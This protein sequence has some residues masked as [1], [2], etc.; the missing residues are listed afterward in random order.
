MTCMLRIAHSK[1]AADYGVDYAFM[2]LMTLSPDFS[3]ANYTIHNDD[4]SDVDI[5]I[6]RF[7]FSFD[8]FNNEKSNLQLELT[9]AYQYTTQ[10]VPTF[11]ELGEHIDAEWDTYGADLGFICETH[12]TNNLFFTPS[13]RFGISRMEN[14]ADYN[15][16]LTNIIIKDQ[17]E[18]TIFNWKT[19]VSVLNLGV[20]LRY[21]WQLLDRNSSIAANIYHA[22]IDSFSES[23]DTIQFS[24]RANMLALKAD[25]I[26]P[27]DLTLIDY[28][29]D[30]VL[31]L[32]S[33][34][35]FGENRNTL[36][37]TTSYQG[38][39]GV[40]FPI[41]FKQK[42]YGYLRLSGQ[43]LRAENM[44]GWLLTLGHNSK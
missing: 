24:E 25:M 33:N 14:H 35:F 17:F 40:E 27:T 34:H 22:C 37:Y 26:F 44:E 31:L 43:L 3:A 29:I 4:G 16:E 20:G 15:G 7:P 42:E 9:L 11:P 38:G 23:N 6:G 32:G 8:L 19:Y 12:L 5:S 36:G 28:R 21:N 39:L 2:S 13:L 1:S 18:G 10:T 30:F 41:K